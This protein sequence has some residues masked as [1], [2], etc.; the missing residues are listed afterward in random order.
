[1][2]FRARNGSGRAEKW[3]NVSPC[4][5]GRPALP[6]LADSLGLVAEVDAV[7]ELG[8]RV[9]VEHDPRVAPR[10]GPYLRVVFPVEQPEA[11]MDKHVGSGTK[12]LGVELRTGNDFEAWTAATS[13]AAAAARRRWVAV[14]YDKGNEGV[15]GRSIDRLIYKLVIGQTGRANKN[16]E[17]STNDSRVYQSLD[18][19]IVNTF[20]PFVIRVLSEATVRETVGAAQGLTIFCLSAQLEPCL[21]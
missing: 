21:S 10:A 2:C 14:V 7:R 4:L 1:M 18:R 5:R 17:L 15:D 8:H 19:S 6:L 3:T 12:R 11:D 9:G 20:I 13:R 16:V